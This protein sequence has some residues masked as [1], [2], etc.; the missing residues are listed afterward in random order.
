[1]NNSK[2]DYLTREQPKENP[3][4]DYWGSRTYDVVYCGTC[5]HTDIEPEIGKCDECAQDVCPRC[6]GTVYGYHEICRQQCDGDIDPILDRRAYLKGYLDALYRFAW[7]RDGLMY[8]GTTGTTFKQE[9]ERIT[10]LLL[11]ERDGK[12][13]C[14]SEMGSND[15]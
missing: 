8:V 1:M 13:Y 3:D 9:S 11:P 10:Q 7:M 2:L 12:R 6:C 15:Q 4:P 5:N 14:Q